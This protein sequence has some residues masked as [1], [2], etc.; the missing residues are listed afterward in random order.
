MKNIFTLL[1]IMVAI[2]FSGC[3][4]DNNP[5]RPANLINGQLTIINIG[6]APVVIKEYCH[7]RGECRAHESLGV[8]VLPDAAFQFHNLLE[9]ANEHK[10]RA[11]DKIKIT[12]TSD[13]KDPENHGLPLINESLDLTIDGSRT[14]AVNGNRVY[15]RY[16]E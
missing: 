11:G 4:S 9:P 5:S 12:I 14:I 16:P 6:D 1:A 15:M 2:I 10:F 7:I 3:S 8:R 13:T